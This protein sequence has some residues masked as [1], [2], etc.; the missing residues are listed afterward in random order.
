MYLAFCSTS[1]E[2]IYFS[3]NPAIQP[4][5]KRQVRITALEMLP[6]SGT[7]SKGKSPGVKRASAKGPGGG[8]PRKESRSES[9]GSPGFRYEDSNVDASDDDVYGPGEGTSS[10]ASSAF[11]KGGNGVNI[12]RKVRR[13]IDV[14]SA[15]Y[16]DDERE[17][18]ATSVDDVD[19]ES[20]DA[21]SAGEEESDVTDNTDNGA[22]YDDAS[23]DGAMFSAAA[24]G[25]Q[26]LEELVANPQQ[27]APLPQQPA[28]Q[29]QQAAP[30]PAEPAPPLPPA[31][32][33]ANPLSPADEGFESPDEGATEPRA[34][35]VKLST[36]HY[37]VQHLAGFVFPPDVMNGDLQNA[38][39]FFDPRQEA[40]D[41]Y[42]VI[43]ELTGR[44]YTLAEFHRNVSFAAQTS[45]HASCGNVVLDQLL[46]IL[47]RNQREIGANGDPDQL[48]NL[49]VVHPRAQRDFFRHL[50]QECFAK[51][52][53]DMRDKL[54]RSASPD[55]V[56]ALMLFP[57]FFDGR[58]IIQPL[59]NG[60][61]MPLVM[62]H[63]FVVSC[64]IGSR[65]EQCDERRMGAWREW[66]W[67]S[68]ALVRISPKTDAGN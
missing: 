67:P 39:V 31:D 35:C 8:P 10:G 15:L 40:I 12:R 27:P 33:I 26:P 2:N 63:G 52:C 29:P 19:N 56:C 64:L 3:L 25:I 36:R 9:E 38:G 18:S 49:H 11:N 30:Q 53:E 42:Q 50:V 21:Q 47:K 68:C 28:P 16:A 54:S 20:M 6:T 37:R 48:I 65:K 55:D 17:R 5:G 1:C 43:N 45:G 24:S 66:K 59:Y 7:R 22:F 32:L 60:I 14:S 44:N 62:S 51:L 46:P 4:I 41:L 23:D 57:L 61:I 58:A 13:I 34:V